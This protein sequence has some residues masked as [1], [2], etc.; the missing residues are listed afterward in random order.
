MIR[1]L[2]YAVY[3]VLKNHQLDSLE[4]DAEK[5]GNRWYNIM[6]RVYLESYRSHMEDSGYLPSAEKDFQILLD[7]FLLEKAIYELIYEINN[8]PDWI[9]IPIRGIETLIEK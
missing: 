7:T 1:S 4:E 5:W 8:R 3:D 6:S 9:G 2:H